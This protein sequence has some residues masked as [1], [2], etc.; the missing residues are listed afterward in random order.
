MNLP[1]TI[2]YE[3]FSSRESIARNNGT[4]TGTP[5]VRDG[6][7]L[8]GSTDYVTYQIP[9]TLFSH[10]QIS[11][12]VEFIPDFNWDVDAYVNI[13]SSSGDDYYILKRQNADGNTL[14]F[15]SGGVSIANISSATYSGYWGQGERNT[16]VVSFESGDTNVWLNGFQIVTNDGSAYSPTSMGALVIGASVAG[17]Y[18]FDGTIKSFS[19]H[20]RLFTQEDVSALQN[21][22]LY[23]YQNKASVW[24]DFKSISDDFVLDRSG[25]GNSFTNVGG[26]FSAPGI[27]L[28][29]SNDYLLCDSATGIYGNAEQ[30]IVICFSPDFDMGVAS[31]RYLFDSSSSGRYMVYKDSGTSELSIILGSTFIGSTTGAGDYWKIDGVN[32]FVLVSES[33]NTNAWLNNTQ[34]SISDNTAWSAGNP[35]EIY[36]GA[37]YAPGGFF[38]GEIFHFSTYPIKLSSIQAENITQALLSEYH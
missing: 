27:D 25:K 11:F 5:I 16:I 23:N 35:T 30:S 15:V 36:L 8:N 37:S 29:G 6:L 3:D 7:I 33:G 2:F 38:D 1:N 21:N 34:V 13:F 24:L 22:S 19:I 14:Q 26:S 9:S 32:V 12:V 20:N 28:D 18:K 4:L 31:N 17:L 10:P